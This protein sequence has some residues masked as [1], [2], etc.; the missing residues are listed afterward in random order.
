MRCKRLAPGRSSKRKI[1]RARRP[2][3]IG[4]LEQE[5]ALGVVPQARAAFR[6]CTAEAFRRT[7]AVIADVDRTRAQ[8]I[9]H[10][11]RGRRIDRT[12]GDFRKP[13]RIDATR[14]R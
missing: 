12:P 9:A 1:V 6:V 11:A 14:W 13:P 2:E 3:A 7:S 10:E 8:T 5:F 4:G